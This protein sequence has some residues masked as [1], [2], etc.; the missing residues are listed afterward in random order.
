MKNNK[1]GISEIVSYTLL[2]IIAIGLSIIVFLFLKVYVFKGQSP[3]CPL[4][5]SIFIDE[6]TCSSSSQQ[7]VITLTNKGFFSIN[8]IYARFRKEGRT[9]QNLIN[10]EYYGFSNKLEPG[11]TERQI[12]FTLSNVNADEKYM[13]EIQPVVINEK[14]EQAVCES[15]ITKTITCD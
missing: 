15:T 8:G 1:K 11:N 10:K 6:A 4:D 5:V 2:I 9:V 13:L 7:L 14:N 12:P 3:Q